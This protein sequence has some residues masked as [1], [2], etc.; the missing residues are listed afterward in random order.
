MQNLSLFLVMSLVW[1][2]TWIAA[3]AGV[4][5]VPP[6]FFVAMRYVVVAAVLVAFVRG[7][8]A[9][10]ARDK[11]LRTIIS[12]ALVNVG[13]Y[14]LLF[15]GMQFV[16]SGVAGLIN[17]SLIP[18]ALFGFSVLAGD[19]R[20]SSIVALILGVA[21][22]VLL[23]SNKAGS[24][25]IGTDF[26]G[27][28][29]IVAATFAYALGS[30]LSRP[31]LVRAS[32]IAVTAA[33]A[34]VGAVGLALLSLMLEPVSRDTWAALLAPGPLAGLLFLV[35]G[36]TFVAYTIYL[37]LVRDW[38]AP[39]AGLYAFVSPVVALAA[40]WAVFAEPLGWREI[41]AAMIL[42]AA[43]GMAIKRTAPQSTDAA[44]ASRGGLS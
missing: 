28:A 34:I 13:T 2:L 38:G 30:V 6:I 8:G 15:W 14:S 11:A 3:K 19:E 9:L 35:I 22:L 25:A 24:T 1:G 29:A 44:G 40:G 10:F 18:V 17:L 12:G 20:A 33:Q 7:I 23:F 5:A 32:A 36:G 41:L 43:A 31:L 27:A 39:R 37:R 16:P 26:W 42:F 21:G 4:S